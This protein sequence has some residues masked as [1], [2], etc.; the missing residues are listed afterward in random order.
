MR[1]ALLLA[2][3]TLA[4]GL[5]AVKRGTGMKLDGKTA[6]VTGASR[7][8]G[9]A[10]ARELAKRGVKRIAICARTKRDLDE[11][12]RELEQLGAIVHS[13]VCDLR[14]HFYTTRFIANARDVLG[15]F[16]LLVANA[17][18]ITVA[19][20]EV[21]DRRDFADAM[22]SIFYS[23]LHPALAVL[24]EMRKRKSGTIAF[25]T[26]I[27]GR[28]GVPHLAPYSAAKFAEVGLAE[29][30]R[31]E[32]ASDGVHVL[33]V[34]PGLMRTGSFTRARFKGDAEKEYTWFGASATAPLLSIDADRAARR[35]VKAIERGNAELTF[36]PA[37]RIA[38][39]LAVLVPNVFAAAMKLAGRFLPKAG[40]MP[41][42]RAREGLAIEATSPSKAVGLVRARGRPA[43][44]RHGQLR[45]AHGQLRARSAQVRAQ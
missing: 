32:V 25:I 15:P 39:K 23:A 30:L 45:A 8:L 40:L 5:F 29:A 17:A 6:I 31:A 36:T 43:A 18:T 42:P 21:L 9:R 1:R 33:T 13:E 44:A 37:A 4:L 14:D 3:A 20:V 11:A 27:G 41:V 16:D 26:S 10:I 35:I 2:G 12:R 19:P 24:P 38:S 22:A 7:G 34:V 28:I